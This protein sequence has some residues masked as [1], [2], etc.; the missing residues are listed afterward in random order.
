M[1][2]L[3][4]GNTEV[5]ADT[6]GFL[7]TIESDVMSE[8]RARSKSVRYRTDPA[9][10]V[11]DV[12]GKRWWSKQEEI[13]QSFA[14]NTFTIVKS[15][16]G[17]GKTQLAG[18]LVTWFAVVFPPEETSVLLSAP[19]REQIDTMMF[20]YLRENYSLAA[21]RNLPLPGQ[22]TKWPKWVV[23]QPFRKDLVLPKRPADGNLISSFQ[24]I[25]DT[26]VAVVLD[27]AGGLPEDLFI[28]ANAV[29]TNAFARILGIGN[30]DRLNTA[31]HQRFTDRKRYEM[32][33]PFTIGAEDSPNF[34]GEM[35]YPDDP[36]R[37]AKVKS[38]LV[39]VEW[40]EMM[41]KSAPAGVVKAKVDGEFPDTDDTV[42]FEPDVIAK[43][44]D[45]DLFPDGD[46]HRW[47][48]VDLSYSGEDK[49]TAYLNWGGRIR[50]LSEW[51]RDMATNMIDSAR[52][53]HDLAV[54]NAVTEVRIDRSGVGAGVYEML[55]SNDEFKDRPYVLIGVNGANRTPD[56]NKWL[57]AR[58]WHYWQMRK[59][60]IEGKIDIDIV[61]DEDLRDEMV[62]Q[63]YELTNRNQYKM[64]SKVDMKRAG[65]DSPDH[66]DAAIYSMIDMTA[67]T[68]GAA[69]GLNPGDTIV[70]DPWEL[71][72][73][74]R[75]GLPI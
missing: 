63:T 33:H 57:N 75:A 26:Y 14:D 48:G 74:D 64:T 71:A 16:N 37:D 52:R 25:H 38:R 3:R 43:A 69:A 72:M 13:A 17:V 15:C 7:T 34:T 60:M 51:N 28:G 45:L 62:R 8:W 73:M 31:F 20:R 53:V 56:S 10:W 36:E 22:I 49:S 46:A 30:P 9:A 19:V 6:Y 40:A 21:A 4:L 65:I 18:D 11:W 61:G 39:Q 44:A 32:W 42:W 24:G 12:L 70:L 58:A 29:T 47:M 23:E 67:W 66:L 59:A 41:R 27:E 55:K 5:P 2:E 50:K 68:E 35:I 54:E 1:T